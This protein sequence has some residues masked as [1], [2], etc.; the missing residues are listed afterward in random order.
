MRFFLGTG[1]YT[2]TAAV[3]V[4]MGWQIPVLWQWKAI[5]H[6]WVRFLDMEGMRVSKRIFEWRSLKEILIV[7]TGVTVLRRNSRI[8]DLMDSLIIKGI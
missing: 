4:D 3:S 5:C 2:P 6:Q 1:K 8:F 7:K